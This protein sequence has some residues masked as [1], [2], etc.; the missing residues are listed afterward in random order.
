MRVMDDQELLAIHGAEWKEWIS[1]H[2]KYVTV[3]SGVALAI[4][5]TVAPAVVAFCAGWLLGEMVE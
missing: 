3:V 5:T 2:C 1:K 4:G